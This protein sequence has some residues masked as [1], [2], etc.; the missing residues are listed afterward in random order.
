VLVV[1][2]DPEKHQFIPIFK[3]GGEPLRR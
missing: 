3:P 1:R 2:W